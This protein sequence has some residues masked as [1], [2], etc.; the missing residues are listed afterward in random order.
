MLP[1]IPI[2]WF[3]IYSRKTTSND[4]YFPLIVTVIFIIMFVI[5]TIRFVTNDMKKG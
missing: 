1:G 5:H 3:I 2:F 4:F